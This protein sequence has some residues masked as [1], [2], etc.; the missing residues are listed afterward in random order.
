MFTLALV[1][2]VTLF[3]VACGEAATAV[4]EP[5]ATAAPAAPAATAVPRATAAPT[6]APA[7]SP[8]V[9]A[10]KL[11]FAMPTPDAESNRTWVSNWNYI[12]QHDAFAETLLRVDPETGIAGPLLAESWEVENDFKEWSFK[13]REGIPW[14]FGWGE[15]SAADVVHSF[16]LV[17]REDSLAILKGPA[18]SQATPEIIDDYNVKF[19]FENPYLDGKRLFSR[20][21][22]DLIIVSDAQFK[23]EGEAGTFDII[24][25]AGTGPYQLSARDLG[26][27][28]TYDRVPEG[29]YAYDVDFEQFEYVWAAESLTRMAMLLAGEVQ[30]SQMERVLQPD[31]EGRGMRVIEGTEGAAQT[32]MGFGGLYG[33]GTELWY[34][35]G[36]YG[37]PGDVEKFP[38]IYTPG[39]PLENVNIRKAL[40]KAIDRDAIKQE[41]Y[42]GRASTDYRYTFHPNNEGWNP[43]WVENWEQNYGYNP[44]EAR[45]LLAAE[46]YGPDNPL[47]IKTISTTILGS[48]EL[49]D[50]IEATGVMWA[51][52]AIE[53][54]IEKLDFGSWLSRIRKKQ[55]SNHVLATRNLPIRTTQEGVRIFY[56]NAGSV[57]GYNRDDLNEQYQCLATSADL[58]ERDQCARVIGDILYDNYADIPMFRL[59]ADVTVDPA[60]ITDYVWPG[61]TSAGVSHFHEI[62]GV[63]E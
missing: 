37:T 59:N 26:A 42:L 35:E 62:K 60:Y 40:N 30:I 9:K 14:Q 19:T 11:R 48:P 25:T 49:H 8:K 56:S 32:F 21:A 41:I 12:H 55:V 50:V 34:G 3:I 58:A 31:A 13:L 7:L 38:D 1:V 36:N 4:P 16:N 52:V 33:S 39:L 46:G 29:H 61:M 6:K 15:F 27:T 45:R 5:A 43:A 44:D 24:Q 47:K 18:W 53:L 17:N 51:D 57:W 20:H 2:G 22:G 10:Q 54:E 63:R 28:L 23:S